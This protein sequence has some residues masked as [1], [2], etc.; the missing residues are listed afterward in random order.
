MWM[1]LI[2]WDD[3]DFTDEAK[4]DEEALR[5]ADEDGC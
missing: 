3:T 4:I 2:D 1:N 5:W